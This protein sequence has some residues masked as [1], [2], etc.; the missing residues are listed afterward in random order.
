MQDFFHQ[1]YS[2]GIRPRTKYEVSCQQ[3]Q[4][5]SDLWVFNFDSLF[6][7]CGVPNKKKNALQVFS[8]IKFSEARGKPVPIPALSA[9]RFPSCTSATTR[10]AL[11]STAA[12]RDSSLCSLGERGNESHQTGKSISICSCWNWRCPWLRCW[13]KKQKCPTK[14]K[15]HLW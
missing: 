2:K 1:Q 3:W 15:G 4:L 6:F 7:F 14:N 5:P 13:N 11:P 9:W 10:T 8:V 12:T